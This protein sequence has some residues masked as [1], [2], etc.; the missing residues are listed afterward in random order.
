MA[1]RRMYGYSGR[2]TE[3]PFGYKDESGVKYDKKAAYLF[4]NGCRDRNTALSGNKKRDRNRGGGF[5]YDSGNAAAF[6]SG[7]VRKGW[8]ACGKGAEAGDKAEVSAA[9]Y[10]TVQV[11]EYL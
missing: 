7:N 1:E 4:R 5:T 11:G 2:C 9:G 10:Q 6:S 8:Y 3:E